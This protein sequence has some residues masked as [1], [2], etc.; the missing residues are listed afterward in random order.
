[1]EAILLAYGGRRGE[2]GCAQRPLLLALEALAGLG[3]HNSGCKVCVMGMRVFFVASA[4]SWRCM[5]GYGNAF[6][7][8]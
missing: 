5:L 3:Q 7:R 4:R 2:G 1:M 8:A 6:A